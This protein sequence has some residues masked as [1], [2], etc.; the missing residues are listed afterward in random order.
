MSTRFSELGHTIPL[1]K[2]QDADLVT[3]NEL[4]RRRYASSSRLLVSAWLTGL[5]RT[6]LEQDLYVD[7]IS[8]VI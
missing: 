4:M 1:L 3:A 2:A 6:K 5:S 7:T 8:D